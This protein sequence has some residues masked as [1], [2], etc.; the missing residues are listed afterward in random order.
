MHTFAFALFVLF[1][2]LSSSDVNMLQ[3]LNGKTLKTANG[4]TVK[5][6]SIST[7][8]SSIP[9]AQKA[10]MNEPAE[11]QEVSFTMEYNLFKLINK[12]FF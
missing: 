5:I 2:C 10:P 12:S 8:Q 11:P 3:D 6:S 1:V 9:V 7:S 4:K